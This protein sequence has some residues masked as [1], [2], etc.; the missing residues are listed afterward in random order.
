[1]IYINKLKFIYP[2]YFGF[3]RMAEWFNA[4]RWKRRISETVSQV[5]ILFLPP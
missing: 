5:R 2:I 1:M 3:G 4:R